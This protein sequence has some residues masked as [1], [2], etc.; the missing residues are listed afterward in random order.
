MIQY[1]RFEHLVHEFGH[2][3]G[4]DHQYSPGLWTL[5]SQR[6]P[7][8]GSFM[9]SL[10][11]EQLGWISFH[12]VTTSQTASLR[13]FG[14]YGDAYRLSLGSGQFFLLENHQRVSQ[15]DNP[16]IT[17]AKGLFMLRQYTNSEQCVESRLKVEA[18]DGRFDWSHP[19]WIVFPGTDITVPVFK[20]ESAL[21]YTGKSDKDVFYL[22]NPVTQQYRC[23]DVIAKIDEHS[24]EEVYGS[25]YKGDGRDGFNLGYNTVLSPWSNP[26]SCTQNGTTVN[27]G[28]EVLASSD[29]VFDVQFF[30]GNPAN[31]SP[32]KPQDLR[33]T[34]VPGQSR[35][36]FHPKLTWAAN[37]EPDVNP[38]GQYLIERRHK[39]SGGSWVPW[40]QVAAVNGDVTEWTDVSIYWYLFEQDSNDSLQYRI[41]AKDTQ[42]KLSVYSETASIRKK[43]HLQRSSADGS[44][45]P[46]QFDLHAN[47]PNP[48]NPSSMINYGLPGD[49]MVRLTVYNTLGQEVARLVD[50]VETAGYKSTTFD[51]ATLPSGVYFYRLNA[52]GVSSRTSYTK[53]MKMMMIK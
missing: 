37:L 15:Y 4:L 18:A 30:I 24:G 11:R 36:S 49:A 45:I 13:D 23:Y 7:G 26:P 52:V 48:F 44:P 5:M 41:R 27:L 31:A 25:F 20:R 16:D 51:G 6:R 10:E 14:T 43:L 46:D 12:D 9:N 28:F 29:T 1:P 17:G 8:N 50:A 47:Y 32:S 21:R 42:E 38:S 34:I 40:S 39:F 22:Y 19:Q 3:W 53:V 35:D 33:T 2:V